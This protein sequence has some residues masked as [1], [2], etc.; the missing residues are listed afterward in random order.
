MTING[1]SGVQQSTPQR[2]EKKYYDGEL[3][4]ISVFKDVNGDGKEDLYKIT[5]FNKMFDGSIYER[6]VIDRDG[7]GYNDY[8]CNK[9]TKGG[10]T[11]EETEYEEEDINQVKNRKHCEWEI[12]NRKM[13][14]HQ[15]GIYMI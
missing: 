9:V 4:S 7:D 10:K 13:T 2:V 3:T 1:V 8:L 11:I 15:S 6:T 14:T 5:T 12:Y